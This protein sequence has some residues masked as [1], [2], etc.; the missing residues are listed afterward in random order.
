MHQHAGRPQ[1]HESVGGCCS[2]ATSSRSGAVVT[3]LGVEVVTEGVVA[4]ALDGSTAVHPSESGQ[5]RGRE[6]HRNRGS[7]CGTIV[8][9]WR[10]LP[11]AY[12]S[13]TSVVPEVALRGGNA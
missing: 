6:R 11:V 10:R 13:T 2:R 8:G 9:P 5:R 4:T 12:P 3:V 7:G 1:G